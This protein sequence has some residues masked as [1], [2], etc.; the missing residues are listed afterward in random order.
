[1]NSELVQA[2]EVLKNN[3]KKYEDCIGCVLYDID[4]YGCYLTGIAPED[5]LE[6]CEVNESL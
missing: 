3:C 5:Y 2:L 4:T 6:G 1:M